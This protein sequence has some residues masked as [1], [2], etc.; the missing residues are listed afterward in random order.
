ML[1]RTEA[2]RISDRTKLLSNITSG[3][4]VSSNWGGNINIVTPRRS[5]YEFVECDNATILRR[6]GLP[7][8]I[9][10]CGV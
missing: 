4:V 7:L 5:K 1:A 9:E 10:P 2:N 6:G 8:F 3:S